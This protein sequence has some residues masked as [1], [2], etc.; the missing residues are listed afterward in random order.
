MK[1]VVAT[2]NK[3]KL[4][5]I[6]LA[7]AGLPVEVIPVRDL[8]PAFDPPETGATFAQN[9]RIKAEAAHAGTGLACVADDSGLCVVGLGLEPGVRSSR[10]AGEGKSDA[11]RVE[12]LLAKLAGMEGEAR[13]AWF[14]C[15][16]FAVLP[17]GACRD[18]GATGGVVAALPDGRFGT[19]YAGLLVEGRLHGRIGHAPRGDKGFGYDPIF[20][21]D[22]APSRTLAELPTE[23]KNLISHRGLAFGALARHL[24]I[25]LR[26]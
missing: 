9:A 22:A 12:Y 20:L 1:L 10:Y 15:T 4:E 17:I 19:E 26:S 21:P 11:Q 7:L 5:E 18:L 24:E 2:A 25:Y 14:S 23:E 6:R 8:L 13:R 16:V 3:G